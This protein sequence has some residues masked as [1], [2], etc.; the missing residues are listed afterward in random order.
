M[1]NLAAVTDTD[2][3]TRSITVEQHTITITV[4]DDVAGPAIVTDPSYFAVGEGQMA[5][6]TW[7]LSETTTAF[8]DNPGITF[9][10]ETPNVLWLEG[11]P[12]SC[13]ALWSNSAPGV[14]G[15]S[16]S[17][18]IHLLQRVANPTAGVVPITDDPII[19][20]DPPAPE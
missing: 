15:R 8:F 13:T 12:R 2:M 10:G 1:S 11:S 14:P 16:Y 17:Y 19:H 6:I 3:T 4:V 18:R 5:E 20:N 9:F 7:V